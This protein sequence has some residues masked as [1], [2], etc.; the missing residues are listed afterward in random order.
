VSLNDGAHVT[1][2]QAFIRQID[3][4]NGIFVEFEL[5]HISL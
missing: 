5:G 2:T 4:Q 1:G 3:G